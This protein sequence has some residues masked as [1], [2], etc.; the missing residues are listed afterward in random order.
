[1]I[2]D[3]TLIAEF[4]VAQAAFAPRLTLPVYVWV[5]V[6][7]IDFTDIASTAEFVDVNDTDATVAISVDRSNLPVPEVVVN[8]YAPV[9]LLLNVI[10]EFV[11]V[12]VEFASRVTFPVYV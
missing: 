5:P 6:V 4:V 12:N 9:T 2:V 1:M 11:V 10:A 7:V 8:V 3:V